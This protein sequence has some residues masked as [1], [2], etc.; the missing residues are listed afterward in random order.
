MGFLAHFPGGFMRNVIFFLSTLLFSTTLFAEV[1]HLNQPS[2]N[3]G[4]L[5]HNGHTFEPLTVERT[6]KTPKRVSLY[7][8]HAKYICTETEMVMQARGACKKRRFFTGRCK[9]YYEPKAVERC[10]SYSL[11]GEN[12]FVDRNKVLLDFSQA[13]ALNSN[14]RETFKIHFLLERRVNDLQLITYEAFSLSSHAN[15]EFKIKK[16]WAIFAEDAA[17][18]QTIVFREVD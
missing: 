9:E 17:K 12:S 4:I 1:V 8:T 18:N 6:S 3:L 11:D 16:S 7:F 13:A 2:A 14:E 10:V 15:Y 5:A